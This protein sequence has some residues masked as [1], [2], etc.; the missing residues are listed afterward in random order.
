MSNLDRIFITV[1][2]ER[3][4]NELVNKHSFC[5]WEF[6]ESIVR[7]ADMKYRQ[8]GKCATTAEAV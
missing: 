5:R 6:F 8:E 4:D 1:D 2:E 3:K 7:I